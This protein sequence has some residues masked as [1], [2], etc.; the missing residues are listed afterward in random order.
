MMA[1]QGMPVLRL[2]SVS[3]SFGG[4]NVLSGLSLDV[5]DNEVLG[6]L[7]PNGAGKSTLFNIVAGVLAATSGE[8]F[9]KGQDVT[10]LPAW[11]RCR[12]GIARTYQIPK[13]FGHM[14]VFENTL[15]AGVH[16]AGLRVSEAR[17]RAGDVLE[18]T[19]LSRLAGDPAGTLRL[20]DLKRL[21]LARA[22]ASEPQ[23][24]LLD[25]IAGGLTEGE[26]DILVDLILSIKAE[27]KTVIWVEHVMEALRRGCSR[28]AVIY[29]GTILADGPPSQVLSQADVK[30]I[31]LGDGGET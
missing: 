17:R 29:G 4:L 24:L 8:I 10:G 9:Y 28:L 25:E 2:S 7:G 1:V 26:C 16:G 19:G 20:L 15:V 13:P 22:L 11:T 21:E 31:Y 18:R 5:G 30:A 27:G 23:L 14:S 6:I 12:A 3:K